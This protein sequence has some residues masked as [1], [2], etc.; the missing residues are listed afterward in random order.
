MKSTDPHVTELVFEIAA[1]ATVVLLLVLAVVGG[2]AWWS[3]RRDRD[4]R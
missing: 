4:D 1:Y 3:G 2:W